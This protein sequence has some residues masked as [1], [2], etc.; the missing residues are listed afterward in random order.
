MPEKP[1]SLND[2]LGQNPNLD[3][4]EATMAY[5]VRLAAYREFVNSDPAR[6]FVT[7]DFFPAGMRPALTDIEVVRLNEVA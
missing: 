3:T 6:G 2:F 5:S 7:H 1:G 4:S